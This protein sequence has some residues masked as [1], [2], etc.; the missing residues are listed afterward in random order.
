MPGVDEAVSIAREKGFADRIGLH[1]NLTEGLPLTDMIRECP[2]FCSPNGAFR[3][4]YPFLGLPYLGRERKAIRL[5]LSAQIEKYKSMDLPL[6]H[7]DG[8]HHIQSRIP[9]AELIFPLI[10]SAG[11]RTFRNCYPYPKYDID[12]RFLRMSRYTPIYWLLRK[13][14]GGASLSCTDYF[15]DFKNCRQCADRI[16]ECVV[17]ELMV[18]PRYDKQGILVDFHASMAEISMFV[19]DRFEL[20]SYWDI[21]L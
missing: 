6:M 7:C 5:E 13:L 21:I 12:R 17:S 18:H 14:K 3:G 9:L 20:A 19:K 15:M 8:H 1:L 16:P 4:D 11:F 10:K 2:R